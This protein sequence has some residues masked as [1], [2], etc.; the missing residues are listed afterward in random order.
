MTYPNIFRYL[1]RLS[2]ADMLVTVILVCLLG[3]AVATSADTNA[4][5]QLTFVYTRPKDH[6]VTQ[7]LILIYTEALKRMNI[8]FVFIEVPPR[9]ASAYSNAG[10]VD[11]ELGRVYN[12]NTRFPNLIRVEEHNHFVTF[13]AF[14]TDP[15]I[16]LDRWESLK[17]TNYRVEYRRGLKKAAEQLP[18]VV[19]S[20]RLSSVDTLEQAIRKLLSGRTDVFIDVGDMVLNYLSSQA[21]QDV[22]QEMGQE[23]GKR[24]HP[25]GLMEQTTGHAWLHERH[26]ELAPRLAAVLREM[27]AE[28]LFAVY[29]DQVGLSFDDVKW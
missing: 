25:V 26:R 27:K 1:R 9:R 20:N 15:A 23:K 14:A 19:P 6:P 3:I 4:P 21:F 8:E 18:L 12:Y 22:C 17:D 11:G 16:A 13:L 29:R 5:S 2:L 24:I 28:G 7:W 10:R